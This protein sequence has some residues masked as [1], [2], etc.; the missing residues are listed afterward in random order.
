MKYR[1]LLSAAGFSLSTFL[2][3][4]ACGAAEQSFD[5]YLVD[6]KCSAAV[7]GDPHPEDFIK[8]HTKDC[9]LMANCKKQGYA[10]YITPRWLILDKHGNKL[11]IKLLEKS[12][13]RSGFYIRAKGSIEGDRLTVKT[14][15]EIEEPRSEDS[16][17]TR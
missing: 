3:G 6:R 11:A 4:L 10:I 7:L 8:H 16:A 15:E 1:C 12:A 14:I 2:F 13:R 9:S 17:E 5:G